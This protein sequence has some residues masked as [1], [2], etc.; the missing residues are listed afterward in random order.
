MEI[1]TNAVLAAFLIQI[2]G[3]VKTLDLPIQTPL[4]SSNVAAFRVGTTWENSAPV[5]NMYLAYRPAYEFRHTHGIIHDFNTADAYCVQ[6]DPDDLRKLLGEAKHTKSECVERARV[7]IKRLG[8]TNLTFLARDPIVTSP[9]FTEAGRRIPRYVIKWKRYAPQFLMDMYDAEAEVDAAD[10][11]IK[12]LALSSPEFWKEPWPVT[13]GT[14][15]VYHYP[16]PLTPER[17]DLAVTGMSRDEAVA[18]VRRV[19]PRINEFCKKLTLP[20]PTRVEEGDIVLGASEVRMERGK[21]LAQLRLRNGYLVAYHAGHV[22][23][24]QA[25]DIFKNRPGYWDGGRDTPEYKGPTSLTKAEAVKVVRGF[26]VG[27]LGLAAE[28]L[29]LNAEP[30]F[31]MQPDPEIK[32]GIRRYMFF[33]AHPAGATLQ[34]SIPNATVGAEI[35]AVTGAIKSLTFTDAFFQAP[36]P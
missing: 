9:Q 14:T 13:F 28:P 27:R 35:D 25:P 23:A 24:V 36:E 31:T 3:F 22:A 17:A 6:Q 21:P 29:S 18:F 7:V 2:S 1:A 4:N 12:Y 34:D 11:S 15:N 19:L 30:L 16:N 8:Y 32:K 26:L 5:L 10:L 33:W 20:M